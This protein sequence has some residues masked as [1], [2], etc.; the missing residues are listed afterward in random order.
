MKIQPSKPH[1]PLK[2]AFSGTQGMDAACMQPTSGKQKS[3]VQLFPSSQLATCKKHPVILHN[4]I[5]HKSPGSH[6]KKIKQKKIND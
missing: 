6:Y 3:C 5:L 1:C 2:H 4:P